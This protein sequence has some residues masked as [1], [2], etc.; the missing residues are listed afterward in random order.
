M[1]D[2]L[3]GDP[4][5][6]Q[7]TV[8][9]DGLPGPAGPPNNL[10][11]GNV[12]TVAPEDPANVTISGISPDQVLDFEIPQGEKG[13]AATVTVGD[14]TTTAPGGNATVT[15]SG[16]SY[17]AVLDFELPQGQTGP[18]GPA[19]TITIG[20]V[21]AL[22]TGEPATASMTGTAPNQTLNLGLPKGDTGP[23]FIP[24]PRS[25][26]ATGDILDD[27]EF[28]VVDSGSAVTL[29]PESGGTFAPGKMI[30]V[31]QKGAG[32]V[33]IAAGTRTRVATYGTKTA[34]VGATAVLLFE[35]DT[36]FYLAGQIVL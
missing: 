5:T 24:S 17:A 31:T 26:S 27:D 3:S 36:R 28:I 23:A 9:A 30:M 21:T 33:T 32:Q 8:A 10:T 20:T 25:V 4:L 15:N 34:G 18:T 22:D 7:V 19:T 29:T 16:T 2:V 11:I 13:D 1:A 6:V 14:V 35:S 12:T